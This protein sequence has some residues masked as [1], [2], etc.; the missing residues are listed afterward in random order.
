MMSAGINAATKGLDFLGLHYGG[1]SGLI[2]SAIGGL[3]AIGLC[4]FIHAGL[5]AKPDKKG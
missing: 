3:L 5:K 1:Y 2:G 4:W